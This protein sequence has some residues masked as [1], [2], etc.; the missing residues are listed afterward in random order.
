MRINK[1]KGILGLTALS[2]L[3][4]CGRWPPIV[5]TKRDIERLPASERSVRARGLADSDILSLARLRELRILDFSGG[6]AVEAARI[7][8]TGLV[9][10]SKLDLPQLET[11]TLGYCA[12]ITD[13]GLAHVG[14]MHTVS[15]LSLMGCPQI[16]DAGLS[17]L[18]TMKSLT[19]LDLRGCL[20]ITDSGLQHLAVKTNWQTILLGGCSNVTASGVARLQVALPNSKVEKDEKEWSGH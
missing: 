19:A 10:L 2:L 5:D 16:T 3:C 20:G 14:Q 12:N 13:A 11:L 15:W 7:T 6:N 8:D 18:L 9:R 17:H 4:G 1:V